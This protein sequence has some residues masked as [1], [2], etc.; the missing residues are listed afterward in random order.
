MFTD[1]VGYTALWMRNAEWTGKNDL[2]LQQLDQGLHLNHEGFSVGSYGWLK[3]GS[4][5]DPLRG[6]LRFEKIVASL[7]P[8]GN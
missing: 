7:V 1:M 3:L 2:A 4:F 8:K 5:W 6:D